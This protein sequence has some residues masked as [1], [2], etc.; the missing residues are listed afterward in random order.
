MF[1]ERERSKWEGEHWRDEN[2]EKNSLRALERRRTET[3]WRD[4][5]VKRARET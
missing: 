1:K 4:R 3:R 5:G 2:E